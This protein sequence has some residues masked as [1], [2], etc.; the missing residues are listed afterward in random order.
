MAARLEDLGFAI[1]LHGG[2]EAGKV[3]LVARIGPRGTDGLV[4]S[5]HLDVVPVAGQPWTSD[6]FRLTTEGDR[7]IARGTSDMKGFLAAVLVALRAFDRAAYRRELVLIWTHDEELGCVGS[8]HLVDDWDPNDPLPTACVVG[9]PT[10]GHVQRMHAGHVTVHVDVT[11]RAAHT[12]R[13]DL[14]ANAIDAAAEI[15][16]ALRRLAATLREERADLPLPH[17]FVPLVVGTIRGGAAVNV[18]PDAVQL[19][20]GYRPLPGQDAHAVFHR[21][22]RAVAAAVRGSDCAA[23]TRLGTVAP[24]MLT[25]SGTDLAALLAPH[26]RPG[27]EAAGYATDGGQLARLGTQPLLY[28]PGRIDVAHRADEWIDARE[29]LRTVPVVEALVHARC[30]APGI[31]VS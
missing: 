19:E 27:P 16:L 13:P 12:S 9:E 28:G 29:L 14:G 5:G 6:P 23:V 7:L 8:G 25:P 26:A 31:G 21:V 18:V 10:D 11:G 22:E 1:T 4:L 30:I 24:S 17:P 20:V 2:H 15:V 3:N